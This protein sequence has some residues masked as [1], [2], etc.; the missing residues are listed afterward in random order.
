MMN[1][2]K[3]AELLQQTALNSHDPVFVGLAWVLGILV[4]V[5]AIA[6]PIMGMVRQYQT[7]KADG[8]RDSADE[9]LYTK[10]KEQ[11]EIN[12]ADIRKLI[13]ERNHWHGEYLTLKA[14]VTH[15]EGCEAAMER[16]KTKLDSKDEDLRERDAENR[17]L[18]L[19]IISLKDRL[20]AL[21]MR[22]SEDEKQF[23]ANCEFKR[24]GA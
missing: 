2:D 6:K 8:A 13:D 18:M 3:A 14:R 12:S 9:T 16:M 19:E 24:G 23:C 20:H 10:L 21:E 17:K 5:L 11:I 22:L 15:L 4:M 7:N 1:P